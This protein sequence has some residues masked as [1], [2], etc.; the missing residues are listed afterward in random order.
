MATDDPGEPRVD[1]PR[2]CGACGEIFADIASRC[3]RCNSFWSYRSPA[4]TREIAQALQ[5]LSD[6][7]ARGDVSLAAY[8]RLRGAWEARLLTVRPSRGDR[9]TAAIPLR[10]ADRAFWPAAAPAAIPRPPRPAAPPRPPRPPL[11][12]KLANWAAERQ[13]DILLYLGSFLLTIA[14]LIFVAYQGGTLTGPARFAILTAYTVAFLL[15]G[16]FIRRWERVREAER[17]FLALGALLVPVDFLALRT[18]LLD[19]GQVSPDLLWLW[20]SATSAALY[21]VL[22]IRGYG[23][24]YYVTAI[25]ALIVAWG[26]L[27]S[28]LGLRPAWYGAWF[29]GA[30]APLYLA[31]IV[32]SW[33]GS[34]W[35][36]AGALILGGL[37]LGFAHVA[38]DHDHAQLP[39]AD[40]LAAAGLAIGLR[41]W[42]PWPVLLVL[43]P[44]VA[45]TALTSAWAGA[46]LGR[47][48]WGPFAAIGGFGYLFAAQFDRP[49]RARR[50]GAAAAATGAATIAFSWWGQVL[51]NAAR[52]PI[53]VAIGAVFAG[54]ALAFARWRWQWREAAATLPALA[55]ATALT[56]A[57]AV[58]DLGVEW[59]GLFAVIGAAG[60]LLLAHFDAPKFA[61]RW[62]AAAAAMGVVMVAGTHAGQA[63]HDAARAALPAAYGTVLVG[64]VAAFLRW[65]WEWR[66]AAALI[67]A[68]AALTGITAS[69]AAF[70]LGPEWYGSF[71][72]A[73][74][75]GYLLL[76]AGDGGWARSWRRAAILA[77]IVAILVTHRVVA[78]PHHAPF[79]LPTAYGL[80]LAAGLAAFVRWRWEWREGSAALPALM[81][82]FGASLLWAGIAMPLQWM[83]AWAAGAALGYLVMAEFDVPMRTNW[84]VAATCSGI[85]G[86]AWSHG[87]ALVPEAMQVQLPVTYG[88]LVVGS[89]WDA[90]RRR[91]AGNLLLPPLVSG[92]GA[93]I[94]WA[95][96]A[97][98]RWWG[99]PVLVVAAALAVSERRWPKQALVRRM[100]WT[101]V[102]VLAIV[103][104]LVSLKVHYDH[105]AFGIASQTATALLLFAAA[106][107]ARGGLVGL[108][109]S[110][111]TPSARAAERSLL[112]GAGYA[113]VLAAGASVNGEAG[114]AGAERAWLFVGLAGLT[115]L[116]LAVTA[117]RGQVERVF[118]LGP[119][120]TAASIIGASLAVPDPA[121]AT[122]AFIAAAAGAL[123]VAFSA[124]LWTLAALSS[125]FAQLALWSAWRWSGLDLAF[126]PLGYVVFAAATWLGLWRVRRYDP[127]LTEAGAAID[128]LSWVPWCI[129]AIVAGGLLQHERLVI[130]P[131]EPLVRSREWAMATIVLASTASAIVVEGWRVRRRT[132]WVPATVGLLLAGLMAIGTAEPTNIQAYTA[133]V[134]VYLVALPFTWR[135]TPEFFG[136]HMLAHEALMVVGVLFLVLPPA[137]QSFGADGTKFGLELM[138]IGLCFLALGFTLHARWLVPAGVL[139][140]TGIAVRWLTSGSAEVPYWLLLGLAGTALIAIAV[141]LLAQ[142]ER[143][144]RF[145]DHCARWWI[146]GGASEDLEPSSG[147]RAGGRP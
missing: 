63:H 115:W 35:L 106:W 37:A 98:P 28:V 126:L 142:R 128:Y 121:I 134:G 138:G 56:T 47:D 22:A 69:W 2:Y 99:F 45:L 54:S 137:E 31:A 120:A 86:L 59:W 27:G 24:Y 6:A 12:P 9:P 26:S 32:R 62:G 124:R 23:R 8:D 41:F 102:V 117:A 29:E 110:A 30:A 36:R 114:I 141:V 48:W 34:R 50:W 84:R 78:A 131:G 91:D 108:W 58:F 7:H 145:K 122:A 93:S 10:A 111:L 46:D 21:L 25:P 95:V 40:A 92:L 132:V 113:F 74:A 94:V 83:G 82:A 66:E 147:R 33:R 43:W 112:A 140:Y 51:P 81:A 49:G 71:S 42:R 20:G 55:A 60:Y 100:G 52:E 17:V 39:V 57:W 61:R 5:F 119:A 65:R 133:T 53:P 146:E 76:A 101:Y 79:A 109:V 1:G 107:R 70:D 16:L 123:T 77:A 3:P 143:W 96:G 13:A 88:V 104:T 129:S 130:Q 90:A 116:L 89:A 72:A 75:S 11:G 14:A 67:P 18:Q 118:L 15:T 127:S 73:A 38:A 85:A 105:P 103:P 44:L 97:T 64:S 125:A 144:D 136:R 80:T 135:Q 19:S 4:S 68:A 139:T 87:A